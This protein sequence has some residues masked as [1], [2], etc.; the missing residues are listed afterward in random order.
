[1]RKG[2]SDNADP[3]H[4]GSLY[5][6]KLAAGL[7]RCPHLW[8]VLPASRA[9]LPGGASAARRSRDR[10]LHSRDLASESGV[11]FAALAHI[12]Q[13]AKRPWHVSVEQATERRA[14]D[15]DELRRDIDGDPLRLHAVAEA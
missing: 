3:Y 4:G 11:L 7:S 13:G 15:G 10:I 5:H 8:R 12:V 6:R 2:Y 9:S 14:V 1:V